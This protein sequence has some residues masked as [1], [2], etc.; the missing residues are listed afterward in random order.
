MGT[1]S[2]G[3][4]ACNTQWQE[5]DSRTYVYELCILKVRSKPSS[6]VSQRADFRI[7]SHIH[8]GQQKVVLDERPKNTS[9]GVY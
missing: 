1:G 9:Q 2:H 7:I 5:L 6:R 4:Q 8:P 3:R